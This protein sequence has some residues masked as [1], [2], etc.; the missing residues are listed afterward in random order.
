MI[1]WLFE[2]FSKENSQNDSPSPNAQPSVLCVYVSFNLDEYDLSFISDN[3]RD[4]TMVVIESVDVPS[5]YNHKL[6]NDPSVEYHTRP[7]VGYDVTAWKDYILENYERIKNFDYLVLVNN[8]CRYDFRIMDAIRDMKRKGATFY[9]LNHSPDRADHLQSYFTV[10]D[11]SIVRT[12]AFHNHW[13][14]MRNIDD[15][16]DAIS[17]HELTFMDDMLKA[18]AKVGSLTD[19]S[20]IGSGYEPSRYNSS[21]GVVPPFMKKKILYKGAN[22]I[23][24]ERLLRTLPH[25]L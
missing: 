5:L 11:K 3:S 1:R 8:S 25:M 14:F 18:G 21:M 23:N 6:K 9:G 2:R 12:P 19:Y 15:R 10:A 4:C 20:F 17:K 7:N 16:E 24:Y 22:L 13:L